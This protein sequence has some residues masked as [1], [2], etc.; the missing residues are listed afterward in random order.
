MIIATLPLQDGAIHYTTE[1]HNMTPDAVWAAWH[2]GKLTVFHMW[3]YQIRHG[4]YFTPDG[5]FI[6]G[7]TTV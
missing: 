3:E 1:H 2:A 5:D 7:G 4:G 6:T